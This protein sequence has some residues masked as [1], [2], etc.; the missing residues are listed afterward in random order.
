MHQV[1]IHHPHA[2]FVISF[3]PFLTSIPDFLTAHAGFFIIF[4]SSLY[5]VKTVKPI[6][7][8]FIVLLLKK[9]A[10]DSKAGFFLYGET[11]N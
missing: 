4:S 3:W 9:P 7:L 1:I 11:S 2:H 10:Y 8:F 5:I 6:I